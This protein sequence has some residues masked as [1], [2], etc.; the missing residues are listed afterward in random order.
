MTH[1]KPWGLR[2]WFFTL[3]QKTPRKNRHPP[4]SLPN[5]RTLRFS[6]SVPNGRRPPYVSC[7]EAA[8]TQVFGGVSGQ[9]PTKHIRNPSPPVKPAT[10][11][12]RWWRFQVFFGYFHPETLGKWFPIWR[13]PIFSNGWW[14]N[15]QA[16]DESL[17]ILFLGEWK[18]RR[19]LMGGDSC[20]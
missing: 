17:W 5:P 13:A 8:K 12:P 9:H 2:F 1:V 11:G 4:K 6:E 15:H 16:D 10:I 3:H 7:T 19:G 20:C 14:K 18:K